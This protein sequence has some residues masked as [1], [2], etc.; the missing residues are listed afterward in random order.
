MNLDLFNNLLNHAKENNLV[1]DLIEELGN[2]L[3]KENNKLSHQEDGK[4]GNSL[5]QE[6]GLYQVLDMDIDG[7]YLQNINNNQVAKETDIPKE[8]LDKIGNDSVLKY[9]EGRYRIEEE[10][11]QKFSDSLIGIQEY[12]QIQ[13]NFEKE[14]NILEND[15][16]TKYKI[17]ERGNNKTTLNYENNTIK[18][19]NE[20]IPFWAKEGDNLYY[21]N[22][23]FNRDIE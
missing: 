5:K 10:L 19:P 4:K 13:E 14:S 17:E 1:Q 16:D 7:A 15:P 12:K 22:G 21:K 20:L 8:I 23:K 9:Q 2:Y 6:D 18:V 3:E 11:T